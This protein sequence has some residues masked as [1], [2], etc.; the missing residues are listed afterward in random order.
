MD[1]A[2]RDISNCNI[3]KFRTLDQQDGTQYSGGFIS[4]CQNSNIQ[5]CSAQNINI[6]GNIKAIPT[7][8]TYNRSGGFIGKCTGGNISKCYCQGTISGYENIGGF[9]GEANNVIIEQCYA[10]CD[11]SGVTGNVTGFIGIINTYPIIINNCYV[12][13]SINRHTPSNIT[14]LDIYLSGFLPQVKE[15]N[16]TLDKCYSAV[17]YNFEDYETVTSKTK[18]Y[19]IAY[20]NA[21]A[22]RTYILGTSY[23]DSSLTKAP[24]KQEK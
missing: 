8:I 2:L 19:G 6:E 18:I 20:V 22:I 16:N 4:I 9:I 11:V 15:K 17:N 24:N 10:Y 3:N 21:T 7:Y 1:Q 13:G 14:P 23:Y 12:R 5:N